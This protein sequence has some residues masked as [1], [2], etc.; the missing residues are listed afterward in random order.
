MEADARLCRGRD[1]AARQRLGTPGPSRRPVARRPRERQ[2]GAGRTDDLRGGVPAPSQG[3]SLRPRA[4]ARLSGAPR[5]GR[6]GRPHRRHPSR[7]HGTKAGRSGAARERGTAQAG[8]CRRPGGRLGLEPGNR[9]GR[10]LVALERDARLRRRRNR[11]AH[12]RLGAAAPSR[13]C[14]ERASGE[15]ERETG[16][17]DLRRRVPPAAQGRS[18]RS[19]PLARVSGPP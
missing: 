7:S 18:L 3:R 13:R 10:V 11:T 14:G 4:L 19:R 5:A 15:R 8:V 16:G 2:R 1:R 12:Q 17:V 6:T 9:R